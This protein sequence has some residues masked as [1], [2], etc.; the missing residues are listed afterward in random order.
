MEASI[1]TKV[2]L[3]LVLF[4]V[5]WGMGLALE[6]RDFRRV[7][8]MPKALIIGIS[9]QMIML[10]LVAIGLLSVFELAPALAV[11]LL[12]LSFCPGG[13][14][15][16]M[17]SYLAGGDVA[18]SITL[19]AVV[20]LITPFTIPLL[21]NL[22]MGHWLGAAAVIS[23]PIIK[24]IVVLLVIT[25]LP[26]A[27]GMLIKAKQPGFAERSQ[28]VVKVASIL[29]LLAITFAIVSHEWDHLPGWFAKVG[30]ICLLLGVLTTALGYFVGVVTK[31]ERS[32]SIT[33]AIEVGVQNGATG[34]F[35]TSTLL[36]NAEMSIPPVIYSLG[37]LVIAAG[38]GI[39]VNLGRRASGTSV[40]PA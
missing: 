34:L 36:E 37:S 11:G 40:G 17:L 2:V 13:T 10:P 18:L 16:N 3:P 1:L 8:M 21:A 31:L 15:S 30:L 28:R 38:F 14:T 22:A 4:A 39:L 23:L 27:L 7:G 9:C 24:T 33:V 5:M 35:V 20:S 32:Q 6:P 25:V 26:V 29:A 12:I 19:T